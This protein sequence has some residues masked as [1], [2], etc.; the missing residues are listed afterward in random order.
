MDVTHLAPWIHVIGLESTLKTL[1][2]VIDPA[3]EWQSDYYVLHADRVL[4]GPD[5]EADSAGEPQEL[6]SAAEDSDWFRLG[7]TPYIFSADEER[8]FKTLKRLIE[9]LGIDAVDCTDRVTNTRFGDWLKCKDGELPYDANHRT[10]SLFGRLIEGDFVELL[11]CL[12]RQFPDLFFEVTGTG[13][14]DLHQR[15]TMQNG[16]GRFIDDITWDKQATCVY[17]RNGVMFDPPQLYDWD[18]AAEIV[19]IGDPPERKTPNA[20]RK[21]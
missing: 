21:A 14:E 13:I 3:I 12:S 10:L 15:W 5:A 2:R 1:I 8:E 16:V 4:N 7:P 17:V 20:S 18:E 11:T 6:R 9:K 19:E